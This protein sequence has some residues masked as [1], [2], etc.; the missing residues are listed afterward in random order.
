MT[1]LVDAELKLGLE[2]A[3]RRKRLPKNHG[4]VKKFGGRVDSCMNVESTSNSLLDALGVEAQ[5][6]R[7]A[8]P[9]S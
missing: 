2:N 9:S 3:T 1:C 5:P 8:N 7:E 4:R 6:E